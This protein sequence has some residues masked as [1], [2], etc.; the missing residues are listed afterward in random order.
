VGKKYIVASR[1]YITKRFVSS[2]SQCEGE[3]LQQVA[4]DW[5]PGCIEVSQAPTTKTLTEAKFLLRASSSS[6]PSSHACLAPAPPAQAQYNPMRSVQ[7]RVLTN[8]AH[9]SGA[10]GSTVVLPEGRQ[11]ING[12]PFSEQIQ[13]GRCKTM[14]EQQP[15]PQQFKCRECGKVL[16][17]AYELQEHEK[18]HKGQTQQ[19]GPGMSQQAGGRS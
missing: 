2:A 7:D 17:T 19:G 13:K 16:R 5:R 15:N 18:T 6:S 12:L 3:A 10:S 1:I 9:A 8:F 14:N 11:P 4:R